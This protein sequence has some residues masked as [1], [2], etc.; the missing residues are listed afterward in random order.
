MSHVTE[1]QM[2]KSSQECAQECLK[3]YASC[4]A[5]SAHC[6]ELGGAH[7]GR[8]HQTLLADC[9]RICAT[10]ADLMLRE[11]TLH[12]AMCRVCVDACRAC[13]QSCA[14]LSHGDPMMDECAKA[15]HQCAEACAR[16]PGGMA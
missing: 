10:A 3:C 1:H 15:C 6:L 12:A 11:S 14:S 9:A 5:C 4:T 8:V 7:A 2:N 16:M 13:E